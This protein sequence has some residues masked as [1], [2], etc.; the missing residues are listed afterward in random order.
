MI[1]QQIFNVLGTL[2]DLVIKVS[3]YQFIMSSIV[4]YFVV[5]FLEELHTQKYIATLAQL[6]DELPSCNKALAEILLLFLSRVGQRSATNKMTPANLAVVFG[7]ILFRPETET[8]ESMMNAAKITGIMRFMIENFE[9]IFPVSFLSSP[10]RK[11][12][13]GDP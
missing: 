1:L 10:K 4:N 9:K 7:Q 11:R 5:F 2:V 13:R 6:V 8:V 3:F 12:E